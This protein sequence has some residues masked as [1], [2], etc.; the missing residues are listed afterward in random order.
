MLQDVVRMGLQLLL[1]E[2]LVLDCAGSVV[3]VRELERVLLH[4][5]VVGRC[6][7]HWHWH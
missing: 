3:T 6:H 1:V 4:G 7:W 5:L 2:M